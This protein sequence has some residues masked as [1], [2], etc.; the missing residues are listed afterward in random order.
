I[1]SQSSNSHLEPSKP[2][3]LIG[4]Q[5]GP[6]LIEEQIGIGG[7]GI[8]FSGK[9]SDGEFEQKVA[10]KIIK[11]GLSSDYILRRF[12]NERQTLANL[13]HANI[14]RLLDGGKTS[15]ELPYLI[16]EYIDGI[17]ITEFCSKN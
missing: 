8:V 14:A 9:R 12:Q 6:Y 16:M 7:M 17:P 1:T 10:I 13:Q 5:I 4:K 15:E 11:Y 3:P 2:H